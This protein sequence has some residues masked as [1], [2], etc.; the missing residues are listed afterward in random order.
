MVVPPTNSPACT[1]PTDSSDPVVDLHHASGEAAA[2]ARPATAFPKLVHTGIA[3]EAN[4]SN[5]TVSGDKLTS[6][7]T[8][9]DDVCCACGST[10]DEKDVATNPCCAHG[11]FNNIHDS[12][13]TDQ[14]VVYLD[15]LTMCPACSDAG[16]ELCDSSCALCFSK[17]GEKLPSAPPAGLERRKRTATEAFKNLRTSDAMEVPVTGVKKKHRVPSGLPA[18]MLT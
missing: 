17:H 1:G 18:E 4:N 12:C 7:T 8:D 14:D 10:S 2:A 5:E 3:P 15:G 13:M 11:C 9:A 16:V 6:I